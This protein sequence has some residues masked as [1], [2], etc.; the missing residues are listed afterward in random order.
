[1]YIEQAKERLYNEFK[2]LN[3]IHE[4]TYMESKRL[5]IN[6]YFCDH[7]I[8]LIADFM[9]AYNNNDCRLM[10]KIIGAMQCDI[11]SYELLKSRK[12]KQ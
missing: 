2:D 4:A 7:G 9:E 12:G 1:M 3:V 6:S 5:N 11:R 10:H 8:R